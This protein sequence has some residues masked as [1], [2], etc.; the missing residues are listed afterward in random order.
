[1]LLPQ[2]SLQSQKRVKLFM[3][4]GLEYLGFD[5]R[6]C[7]YTRGELDRM[8]TGNHFASGYFC[9]KVLPKTLIFE[10]LKLIQEEYNA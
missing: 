9:Y 8:K 5:S 3:E 2:N 7:F 1:M 4:Y 10:N 6:I